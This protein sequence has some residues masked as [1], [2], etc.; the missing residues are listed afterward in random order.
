M[1]T[2]PAQMH[3]IVLPIDP[4]LIVDLVLRNGIIVLAIAITLSLPSITH[5]I[6]QRLIGRRL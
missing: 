1:P 4:W 6:V 3:S 2:E 5:L